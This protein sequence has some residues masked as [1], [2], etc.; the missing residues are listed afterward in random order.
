MPRTKDIAVN[1]KASRGCEDSPRQFTYVYLTSAPHSGST[2]VACLLGAHAELSTVGEFGT[3]F[4]KEGHCSCGAIYRECPFWHE[5]SMRAERIGVP[6]DTGNLDL[7]IG[8]GSSTTSVDDVFYHMFPW[9]WVDAFRNG[10]FELH[11]PLRNRAINS[12][13]RSIVLAQ[14]LCRHEGSNVFLDT[15][16]NA[17]QIPFL[18]RHGRVNLKVIS[19][20]RDGRGVTNSLLTR[21]KWSADISVGTWLRSIRNQSRAERYVNSENVFRLRL[22]ALCADP[23]RVLSELFEFCGVD[24]DTPGDCT[25]TQHRHII[26]NSMRM[27]FAGEVRLDE[28]WRRQLS[29]EHLQFF[30]QRAGELNR[31]LGYVN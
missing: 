24:P 6:F 18:A 29:D 5:W 19:L 27:H 13:R 30:E 20:I 4:R 10:L 28:K 16:K 17:L 23:Q 25:D 3:D 11:R 21:E 26:G 12:I 7:D 1:D 14:D 8:P 22:E 9:K 2:L 15:T 31:S